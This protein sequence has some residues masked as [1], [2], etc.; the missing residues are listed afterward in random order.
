MQAENPDFLV[1]QLFYARVDTWDLSKLNLLVIL[2]AN[3]KVG[4]DQTICA[5]DK[6]EQESHTCYDCQVST[7]VPAYTKGLLSS[8]VFSFLHLP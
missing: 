1:E 6:I 2:Y 7:T 8:D 4:Q 3:F 5:H